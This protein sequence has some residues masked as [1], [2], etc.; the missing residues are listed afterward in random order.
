[1]DTTCWEDNN[2]GRLQLRFNI[3][4]KEIL[5][6]QHFIINPNDKLL[7]AIISGKKE[8]DNCSSEFKLRTHNNL[9]LKICYKNFMDVLL[10]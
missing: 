8:E 9:P 5:H 10:F 7:L 2:L 3:T 6:S 4:Y 1:M